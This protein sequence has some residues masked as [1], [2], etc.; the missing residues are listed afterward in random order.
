MQPTT[1]PSTP[2]VVIT[3]DMINDL[4][5]VFKDNFL[6]ILPATVAFF[7]VTLGWRMIKK[8]ILSLINK[9]L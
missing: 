4:F 2:N 1:G 3:S 6:Y 7:A 8:L 5:N 9:N